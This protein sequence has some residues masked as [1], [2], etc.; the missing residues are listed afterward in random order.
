M[1][2][3][4]NGKFC[5]SCGTDLSPVSDALSGKLSNKMQSFGNMQLIEPI[6]C[7]TNHKGKRVHWEGAFGKLFM[8]IAFLVVSVV[9]AFSGK[10][11]G[12]WFWMLIPAFSMLGAGIAQIIQL[13]K[14]EK[15]MVSVTPPET[16]FYSDI[17]QKLNLPPSQTD[18]IRIEEL[19]N[20]GKNIEAIKVYRETFGVGLKEAKEAVDKIAAGKTPGSYQTGFQEP[21]VKPQNSIYDTGDLKPPPSVTEGTTRHLEIN[22]EGETMSLPKTEK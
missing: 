2:N 17:D 12:W 16:Q 7:L 11:E 15:R 19:I 21:Y 1:K 18:Y 20:S 10:G 14:N 22:S 4:D 3:P 13:R 8:G 9:L 6:S 5:R